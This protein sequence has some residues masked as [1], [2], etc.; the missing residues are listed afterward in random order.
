[1]ADWQRKAL[2]EAKLR[3]SWNAPNESYEATAREFLF[4]VLAPKSPFL[5][6]LQ[7]FIETIAPAGAV[8]GL[9]QVVLKMTVPGMPDFFQGTDFWDLSLVDPDNR[10]PVDYNERQ[11]ALRAGLEPSKCLSSWREGRIKQA[12]IKSCLALRRRNPDLFAR[13]DYSPITVEGRMP[14]NFIAFTR[15]L[16]SSVLLAVVPRLVHPILRGRGSIELDPDALADTALLIPEHLQGLRFR[17]LFG[18]ADEAVT[19]SRLAL[20]SLVTPFPMAV[21]HAS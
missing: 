17:S 10:R 12:V 1:M 20:P 19:G 4:G 9:A 6:L 21:L 14:N 8:N 11:R 16:G 15:T 3:T 2:R 13:G 18:A 7:S 5:P